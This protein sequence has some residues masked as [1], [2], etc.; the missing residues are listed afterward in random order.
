[1]LEVLKFAFTD[2]YHFLGCVLLLAIAAA[3]LNGLVH[4]EHN[5]YH[6]GKR[7]GE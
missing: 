4:I 3:A 5:H 7:K 1:M 2:W 6:D